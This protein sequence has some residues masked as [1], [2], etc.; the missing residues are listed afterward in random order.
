MQAQK[1]KLIYVYS[2]LVPFVQKDIDFLSKTYDVISPPEYK[3]TDK[4]R[5]PWLMLKHLWW[6][7]RN[8]RKAKATLVMFGGYWALFPA[9]VGRL[10]RRPVMII[11]GG[12]DCVSFPPLNYGALRK[13]MQRRIIHW[14]YRF[15]TRLL[16]VDGSLVESDYQYD[17]ASPYPKQGYRYFFP[18][19]KTP[20]T[21]IF[22]GFRPEAFTADFAQKVPNS[23]IT[24]ANIYS[25]AAFRLKGIDKMIGLAKA[26]PQCQF[27]MVGMQTAMKA[28][29]GD[30]PPNLQMLPFLPQGEF[31][32]LL[33]RHEFYLQ[34]SISEG[35]PNSLCEG[36]L[37]GCVPIGSQVASIPMIIG[38]TGFVVARSDMAAVEA[39]FAEILQTPAAE[40]LRLGQAARARIQTHYTLAQRESKFLEV[41][42]A[43]S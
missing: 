23:V 3:W 11:L 13:P 15:A 4:S 18:D 1:P 43:Y 6:L 28:R 5:T 21:V 32:P 17:P 33:Q 25:D 26:F 42:Q 8:Q 9:L 19:L 37:C 2:W 30:L 20:H 16:P 7:L 36:M 24:V 41:L 27:T 35:F 39:R 31:M 14:A 34:L 29:L 22:N 38:D 10:Y 12:T 40:R